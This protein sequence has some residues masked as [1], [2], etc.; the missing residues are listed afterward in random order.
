MRM[1]LRLEMRAIDLLHQYS[2]ENLARI[3][4][5]YGEEKRSYR[6]AKEIKSA[7]NGGDNLD[8]TFALRNLIHRVIKPAS[9]GSYSKDFLKLRFFRL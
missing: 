1:D 4:Y 5:E 3:F 6:V 9:Y 7:L 2:E 8:S